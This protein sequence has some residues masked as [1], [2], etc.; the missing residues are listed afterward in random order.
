MIF[1]QACN[2]TRV[3]LDGYLVP[4]GIMLFTTDLVCGETNNNVES[5]QWMEKIVSGV[6]NELT[7]LINSIL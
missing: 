2:A 5:K 3:V 6:Q 7:H 4:V 1:Q